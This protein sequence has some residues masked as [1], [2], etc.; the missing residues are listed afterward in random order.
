MVLCGVALRLVLEQRCVNKSPRLA[1]YTSDPDSEGTDNDFP[2][3]LE[4]PTA[5]VGLYYTEI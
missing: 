3:S 5:V 1:V 4:R 2:S